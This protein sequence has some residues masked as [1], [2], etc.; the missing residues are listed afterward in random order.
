MQSVDTQKNIH[1]YNIYI[2]FY[3]WTNDR[4][5]WLFEIHHHD[6]DD[7]DDYDDDDTSVMACE[8]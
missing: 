4:E 1:I 8:K 3:F 2:Q 6:D 5:W 7:D